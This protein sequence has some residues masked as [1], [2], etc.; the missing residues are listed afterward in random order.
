MWLSIQKMCWQYQMWVVNVFCNNCTNKRVKWVSPP[1]QN[2][3]YSLSIWETTQ[4]QDDW[5]KGTSPLADPGGPI[6]T[7]SL[8][9]K[10]CS[11]S[12]SFQA[13]IYKG[14]PQLFWA[15]FGLRVPRGSKLHWPPVTKILDPPVNPV[16]ILDAQ[17]LS[18]GSTLK[19][20]QNDKFGSL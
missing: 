3:N 15:N 11:K 18:M 6:S 19:I 2:A 16:W 4:S 14:N 12:C 5:V 9:P 7:L 10:I 13:I 17:R 8:A 20:D 1:T